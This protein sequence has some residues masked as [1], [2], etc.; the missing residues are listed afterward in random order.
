MFPFSANHWDELLVFILGNFAPNPNK[1]YFL[2]L[3]KF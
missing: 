2:S 1:G 3:S